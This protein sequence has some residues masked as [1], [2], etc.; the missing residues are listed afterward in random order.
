MHRII[1]LILLISVFC[2]AQT[3]AVRVMDSGGGKATDGINFNRTSIGQPIIGI[4]EDSSYVNRV[5]FIRTTV[6]CKIIELPGNK[7]KILKH[8]ISAPFPN[9]F[10]SVCHINLFLSKPCQVV[11]EVFDIIGKRI[12]EKTKLCNSGA[13]VIEFRALDL[14]SGA[15]FYRITMD[16]QV[17]SGKILLLK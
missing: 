13:Y 5:G 10:N 12:F 1:I 3:E 17:F 6:A 14:E 4:S 16:E 7:N 9:P 2:I 11:F 15:Y 8:E